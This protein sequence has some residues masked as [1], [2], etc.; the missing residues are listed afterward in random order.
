[1]KKCYLFSGLFMLATMSIGFVSCG[2]DDEPDEPDFVVTPSKVTMHYDDQKQLTAEG[3][4]S[5]T[6]ND[7]FIADVNQTGLV[8]AKHVGSTKIVVTSPSFPDTGKPSTI[9]S[10]TLLPWY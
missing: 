7:E 3:A 6:T 10:L 1:M 9:K 2:G 5:W 4:V 8:E